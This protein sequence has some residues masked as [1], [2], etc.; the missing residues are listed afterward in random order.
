MA[1]VAPGAA[2]AARRRRSGPPIRSTPFQFTLT[3][4]SLIAAGFALYP[5]ARVFFAF[6]I[7]DGQID[8]SAFAAVF[9]VRDVGQIIVD[10]VSIVFVSGA[11]ALVVGAVLAW[12]EERTDASLGPI[13]R[14]LP[15]LPF[16]V[17]P[18]A[19]G[20]GW[21]LLFQPTV[22][23]GNTFI[24][25]FLDALGI[26]LESGPF[27]VASW[28]GLVLVL[29]F[30]HVPYSYMIVSSGLRNMDGAMEE[31]SRVSGAGVFRTLVWVTLPGIRNSLGSA[32]LLLVF[33]GFADYAIPVVIGTA[34]DIEVISM[35]VVQLMTASYPPEIGAAIALSMVGVAFVVSFW[36]LQ[37][38]L[39]QSR[40]FFA[41]GGRAQSAAIIRL[42][43]WRWPARALSITFI[44]ITSFLPLVGLLIVAL[45]GYWSG[46]IDPA[47][48]SLQ[49]FEAVLVNDPFSVKSIQ[50]SLFLAVTGATIGV[51]VAALAVQFAAQRSDRFR[52]AVDGII[53][54]PATVS[55]IIV[56]IGIILAF[57]GPPFALG[58][59]LA[60][61]LIG[62]LVVYM[63]QATVT[64]ESSVA[65]VSGE[66]SEASTVSG[67]SP[68][69]TWTKVVVPLILP[70]LVTGWTLL[71]V[72]MVS[73][74]TASAM[75][76][77]PGTSVI[78]F[79]ILS[80]YNNGSYGT[81]A[82]LC[83]FVTLVTTIVVIAMQVVTG[84]MNRRWRGGGTTKVARTA[85]ATP[86]SDH[87]EKELTAR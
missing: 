62:Y 44:L 65:Q 60:I 56:T 66:L 16:L 3:T 15:I 58:G 12:L 7:V 53:K 14:A 46:S 29:A 59:T 57:S 72:R 20:I 76:A 9:Q 47:N 78:G 75:L 40:R 86:H 48:F 80:V 25:N 79:R 69:N 24:R 37:R 10:T 83:L 30:V 32:A 49:S 18:I 38:W 22:G 26:H 39:L 87:V 70:G 35:R 33:F 84:A 2:R 6:F 27:N 41:I 74:L 81:L 21:L 55:I 71:F 31:Q 52:A 17:P 54:A 67:A 28:W 43:V 11:I 45:H 64:I 13:G 73:D 85:R 63:P 68:W 51:I 82:A 19:T 50:N 36:L 61:L 77:G 5:L 8:L 4:V 42:G 23:I 34:A 1:V